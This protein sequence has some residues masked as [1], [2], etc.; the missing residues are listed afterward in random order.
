M[1]PYK[2]LNVDK[3]ASEK[4]IF[5]QYNIKI[6]PY[7]NRNL[8]ENEKKIVKKFTNAFKI[9]GNYQSRRKYDNEKEGLTEKKFGCIEINSKT[10]FKDERNGINYTPNL[11]RP[12]ENNFGYPK[13]D[14]DIENKF[15]MSETT[16][17]NTL[18]EE[19]ESISNNIF[20]QYKNN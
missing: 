20:S 16:F 1:D 2:I 7:L 9:I 15:R 3:N 4:E 14:L 11:M 18:R 10:Q 6:K 13:I 5:N 8:D 12:F 17:K 19:R